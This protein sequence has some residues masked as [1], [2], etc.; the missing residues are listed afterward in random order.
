M[1]LELSPDQETLRAELRRFLDARVSP[2]V[3]RAC[4]EQPG[5]VDRALW[6]DLGSMGVFGL[7]VP[8]ADGGVGLGWAEAVIV[9]EELGRAA[10]PGPLLAT[11]LAA[12]VID[13]AATGEV[14]V[15]AVDA[16]ATPPIVL[17][18]AGGLDVVLVVAD[19]G[20]S[21]AEAPSDAR[22]LDRPLDPL[23]PVALLDELPEGAPLGGADLATRIRRTAALLAA[24]QQVG[25]GQ[26]AVDLGAGYAQERTQF[27]RPIGSFQAVKHLLADAHVDIDVARAAVHAAAVELDEAGG[28]LDVPAPTCGI[29]AVRIVASRA[30]GRATAACVQ[31][32]GGIGYTWEV[33]AHLL[34]KRVA[35]LDAGLGTS[36]EAALEARAEVLA[37]GS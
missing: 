22:P 36:P 9:F 11:H 5:A 25:L 28:D 21:R 7:R 1:D 26:A 18:H 6:A 3:R 30:A 37:A 31:V 13:G 34:L 33:D 14:V 16:A 24:A 12:G 4:A 17:E 20:V 15:G 10:V 23:T 35:V 27:G 2:E 8:E 32:H 29:D 19:G